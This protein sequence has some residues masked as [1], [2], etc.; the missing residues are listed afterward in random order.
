MYNFLSLFFNIW[1]Q[2]QNV[3]LAGHLKLVG[4][5]E[6]FHLDLKLGQRNLKYI[7]EIKLLCI[8][9]QNSRRTTNR[10]EVQADQLEVCDAHGT[11]IVHLL[12]VFILN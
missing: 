9:K 1:T 12:L 8:N 10:N 5:P 11:L 2:A 6:I 7:S 3:L 4:E